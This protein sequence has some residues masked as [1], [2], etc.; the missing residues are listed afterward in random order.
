MNINGAHITILP[1]IK[2]HSYNIHQ[3]GRDN[4]SASLPG[5]FPFLSR[6]I[7]SVR[8]VGSLA[9]SNC[10][11]S[12]P[13]EPAAFLCAC[14]MSFVGSSSLNSLS[15]LQ[16]SC[17]FCIFF[18]F[19]EFTTRLTYTAAV[20]MSGHQVLCFSQKGQIPSSWSL[21]MSC[22][23]GT[24][25]FKNKIKPPCLSSGVLM[26][27]IT[28]M[29]IKQN[30]YCFIANHS[31]WRGFFEVM[32]I[33]LMRSRYQ[34]RKAGNG[35][36]SIMCLLHSSLHSFCETAWRC[37]SFLGGYLDWPWASFLVLVLDD[38]S[39]EPDEAA[40]WNQVRGRN[41]SPRLLPCVLLPWCQRFPTVV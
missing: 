36:C 10:S 18:F 23:L 41:G 38:Y 14:H 33:V 11:E 39:C 28:Q 4:K 1:I 3:L 22:C 20:T 32:I 15:I 31:R 7:N 29:A 24:F 13:I 5:P 16:L 40:I 25:L 30:K 37:I 9:L 34:G 21:Q 26:T 12:W 27:Y 6:G 2:E 17:S 19:W 8:S 35:G